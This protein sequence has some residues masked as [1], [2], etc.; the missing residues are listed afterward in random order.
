ML[1]FF[2]DILIYSD[3]IEHHINHLALVF[4]LMRQHH[5]YIKESKCSFMQSK[6]EYLGHSIS[7]SGV[8]T[9]PRKVAEVAK[10]HRPQKIKE[11][12]SF[13]GLTGYYKSF[14]HGIHLQTST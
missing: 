14:V 1:Y 12:K 9:D 6:V 13:L 7:A 8:E 10:W 4:D 3:F 11:L 5:M 2:D